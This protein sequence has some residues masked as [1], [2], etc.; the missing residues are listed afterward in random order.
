[1]RT[2]TRGLAALVCG[3]AFLLAAGL[4]APA[5]AATGGCRLVAVPV[6]L[7]GQKV[8]L[9]GTLCRPSGAEPAALQLLLA[10]ATFDQTYWLTPGDAHAKP[11]VT[12][13]TDAGYA[14][15][16]LDRPGSGL[17]DRPPAADADL[18]S[19][20]DAVHQVVGL[21]RAGRVDGHAYLRLIGVGHSFGSSV[22]V[23]DAARNGDLDAVVATGFVHSVGPKLDEL[24]QDI[25]PAAGD[26]VLGLTRPPAGYLTT[27]PGTRAG[28]FLDAADAS[29]AM[30]AVIEL[31]KATMTSGEQ[32]T[33]AEAGDPAVSGAV[34]VPV[35][36]AVG[37]HDDLFCNGPYLQCTDAAAVKTWESWFYPAEARLETYVLA[38]AGHALNLHRNAADLFAAVRAWLGGLSH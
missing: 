34:H 25:V 21:L 32:A 15:L 38:G 18:G 36:V 28:L 10:G 27:K 30:P 13:M 12:Y 23:T 1:M 19:E 4:P 7:A 37:Q 9:R 26:P 16:A 29:P 17:S 3:L 35:F 14:V 2:I 33:L 5:A 11:Y 24:N 20:V 6:T 8:T 31:T 22:L